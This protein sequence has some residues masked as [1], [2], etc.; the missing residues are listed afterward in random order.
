MGC[1]QFMSRHLCISQQHN[2]IYYPIKLCRRWN[3]YMYICSMYAYAAYAM[4]LRMHS[5]IFCVSTFQTYA[6]RHSPSACMTW[7][8]S[9]AWLG[10][11]K[12]RKK[13][14]RLGFR[15][16]E[17]QK[18]SMLNIDLIHGS[19][20]WKDSL[21]LHTLCVKHTHCHIRTPHSINCLE[22]CMHYALAA[23]AVTYV[24]R[25]SPPLLQFQLLAAQ[26]DFAG[27]ICRCS[28][29]GQ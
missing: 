16:F 29:S 1:A 17:M 23:P 4:D 5:C 14:R 22:A 15:H 27:Q 7:Q 24:P 25:Y 12:R 9:L 2:T 21:T 13:L 19:R 26:Y 6:V 3:M 20:T 8:T 11:G 18:S 10:C 28:S